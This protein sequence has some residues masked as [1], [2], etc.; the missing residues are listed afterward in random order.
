MNLFF[1]NSNIDD[2]FYIYINQNIKYDE[3]IIKIIARQTVYNP[4]SEL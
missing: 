2:C 4:L 3:E 1:A